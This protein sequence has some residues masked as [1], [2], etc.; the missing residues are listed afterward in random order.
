MNVFITLKGTHFWF[1]FDCW[2]DHIWPSGHVS[3]RWAIV[4]LWATYKIHLESQFK[5][6]ATK[7][8]G[9]DYLHLAPD[10]TGEKV[11][12]TFAPTEDRTRDPQHA[13]PTQC[14]YRVA[15]EAIKADLYHNGST[16][17]LHKAVL[18]W[19]T[20]YLP[21]I[22]YRLQGLLLFVERSSLILWLFSSQIVACIKL[23]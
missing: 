23:M 4:G 20:T 19:Y 18:V 2:K 13:K 3:L 22:Q 6:P 21:G 16:S 10:V 17:V 5:Q 11:L 9:R 8:I 7:P 14:L 1:L 15:I 12:I